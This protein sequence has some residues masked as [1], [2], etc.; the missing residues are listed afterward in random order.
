MVSIVFSMRRFFASDHRVA[1]GT[2]PRSGLA[3]LVLLVVAAG[4]DIASLVSST[5]PSD[6]P[7]CRTRGRSDPWSAPH[8]ALD[9][10]RHR[11]R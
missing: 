8:R 11:V 9:V 10:V 2:T 7:G 4:F 3:L 6:L 5:V 1:A